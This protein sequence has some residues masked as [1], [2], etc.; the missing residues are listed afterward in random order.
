MNKLLAMCK[1]VTADEFAALQLFEADFG[2]R[3]IT[4]FR[5]VSTGRVVG[6][7]VAFGSQ[8]WLI[9]CFFQVPTERPDGGAC[10]QFLLEAAGIGAQI[11]P[12][13]EDH[14]RLPEAVFIDT[15]D[16][17]FMLDPE[18]LLMEA[19]GVEVAEPLIASVKK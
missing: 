14:E 8:F 1:R 9:Y 17:G 15:L 5:E 6:L 11:L 18:Q 19:L 10:A 3:K 4:K 16:E 12:I 13:D 7:R 2:G